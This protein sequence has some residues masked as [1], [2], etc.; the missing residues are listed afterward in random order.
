[1]A[2]SSN[3]AM[4]HFP[5]LRDAARLFPDL[6]SA[7]R[8]LAQQLEHYHDRPDIV[9]LALVRGGTPAAVEVANHLSLPADVVLVRKLLAPHGPNL[10]ICAA[11]VAGN[12]VLDDRL[13]AIEPNAE[14]GFRFFLSDAIESLRQ[15]TE[16]CRG[17][18]DPVD[19]TGKTVLLIDN[20]ARTGGTLRAAAD[21]LRKLNPARIVVAIA[22][23]SS[24]CRPMLESVADELVC[25]AWHEA[26][27]HVGMWYAK[28]DVP[29]VEEVRG[30]IESASPAKG[31]GEKASA[32]VDTADET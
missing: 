16:L 30:M 19:L 1:M 8:L 12:L 28:Y 22:V 4:R 20:G 17:R 9:V 11:T 5:A 7:G 18:R 2:E 21:A 25:L 13:P 31:G 14:P 24:D 6:R 29:A 26:F 23:G 3:P 27:G 10:P 15:R 32:S